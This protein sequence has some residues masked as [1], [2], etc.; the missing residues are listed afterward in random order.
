MNPKSVVSNQ[1]KIGD[2]VMIGIGSVVVNNLKNGS[3]VS[4]N[5]AID[6]RKF[7]LWHRKKLAEK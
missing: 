3:N 6:H 7:L 5:Y 1:V 4:G 2:D